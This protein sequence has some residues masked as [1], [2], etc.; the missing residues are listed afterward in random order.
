MVWWQILMTVGLR[1]MV[2]ALVTTVYLHR[3]LAHGG[4]HITPAARLKFRVALALGTD[5]NPKEWVAVHRKHHRYTDREGDPHSPILEGV[6][7]GLFRVLP[8]W[9]Q[10]FFPA[11]V[12][13]MF[14]VLRQ[15]APLYTRA[16]RDPEVL[17]RYAPDIF[18]LSSL[19]QFLDRHRK[20]G[21]PAAT[22]L[23]GA[24]FGS[25]HGWIGL[26]EGSLIPVL[27]M[28][29]YVG[30]GGV[31]NGVG[32]AMG[33]KNFP[34]SDA[35]NIIPRWAWVLLFPAALLGALLTAGEWAHN[36]HHDEQGNPNFSRR[37]WEIDPAWPVIKLMAR[38]GWVSIDPRR[39]R[40]RPLVAA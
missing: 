37:W 25:L 32:H 5:I 12:R 3:A 14:R 11:P 17:Q 34:R 31:I 4:L 7:L 15:N 8:K 18:S 6:P 40:Q 19:E 38:C 36:N 22:A 9:L 2:L 20:A 35:Y 29:A 39:L 13:G 33:Y 30:A 23:Y 28:I 21:W 1:M 16:A 24:I 27:T 26:L 10:R